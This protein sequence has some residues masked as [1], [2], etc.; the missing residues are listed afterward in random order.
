MNAKQRRMRVSKRDH[1]F[2]HFAD[3]V[4]VHRK[5][6]FKSKKQ[7]QYSKICRNSFKRKLEKYLAEHGSEAIF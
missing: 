5:P 4:L 7:K 2:T 3:A 6:N 1:Y